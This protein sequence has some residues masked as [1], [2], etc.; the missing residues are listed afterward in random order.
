MNDLH[1]VQFRVTCMVFSWKT[2]YRVQWKGNEG[3]LRV[4]VLISG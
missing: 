1:T 2:P 3:G 4:N